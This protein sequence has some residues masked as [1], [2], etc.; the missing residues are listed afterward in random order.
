VHLFYVDDSG[1]VPDANQTHFI[2]A[3]CSIFERGGYWVSQELD[4]IAARFCPHDPKS[5][6]LHGSPMVSGRGLW[7]KIPQADRIQAIIDALDVLNTTRADCRVFGACVNKS[8]VSPNDP[9]EICFEQISSRF[10]QFLLRKHRSN[11]T[12]R[13]MIIFDKSTAETSIQKLAADFSSIGHQW[14]VLRNMA[15]VPSFIDSRASRI[16][17]LADLIA[18]GM[19]RHYEKGDSRFFNVF[20][21]KF[22]HVGSTVHGLYTNL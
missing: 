9:I 13:G 19:F 5:I 11:D 3:G 21:G 10:D 8:K 18:Y 15:E 22:D 6:E 7:R 17:Q 16:I 20:N 4:K 1:S 12:Q 2:L 14:G